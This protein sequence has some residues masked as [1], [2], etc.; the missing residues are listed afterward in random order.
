MQGIDTYINNRAELSKK[1]YG[2]D[3]HLLK[4]YRTFYYSYISSTWQARSKLCEGF[5]ANF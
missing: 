4:Y 1:S 5:S 3:I 2:N